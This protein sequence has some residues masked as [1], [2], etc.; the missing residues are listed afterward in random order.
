MQEFFGELFLVAEGI[1]FGE[2]D[3]FFESKGFTSFLPEIKSMKEKFSSK[4]FIPKDFTIKENNSRKEIEVSDLPINSVTKDIG[5]KTIQ[6]FSEKISRAKLIVFNGTPGVFEEPIFAEG[7]KA[8]LKSMKE[9]KGFTFIG[10]G[11]TGTALNSL[12]FSSS[13]FSFVSL[14]GK[15]SLKYLSGKKLV[16]VEALKNSSLT[17]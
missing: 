15:A 7:T 6:E 17:L 1:K 8:V 2:K 16:A 13:D 12:G 4:I 3:V 10:G 14:S 9:N 5:K 11:D